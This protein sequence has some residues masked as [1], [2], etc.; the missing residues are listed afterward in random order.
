[1]TKDSFEVLSGV[2]DKANLTDDG[3]H[4]PQSHLEDPEDHPENR[5]PA[6]P[7]VPSDSITLTG[8]CVG[9]WGKHQEQS[10]GFRHYARVNGLTNMLRESWEEHLAAF[11]T[12]GR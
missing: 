1:M 3:S 6:A 7:A 12:T 9:K 8:F 4:A 2:P 10:A 5:V 11:E